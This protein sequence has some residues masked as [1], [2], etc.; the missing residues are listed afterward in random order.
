MS[1]SGPGATSVA[2]A[3]LLSE[4]LSQA[5]DDPGPFSLRPLS[6]GNSNETLELSSDRVSRI[7]RRPP[8]DA[9][10]PSA[11]NMTREFRVLEALH[12]TSVPAPAPLAICNDI[13]LL[14]VPFMVM[15]QVDG[16]AITDTLPDAYRSPGDLPGIGE[17]VIDGLA[18]LQ[19]V[20]WQERGLADFGRPEG[21]LAR[22]LPRWSKQFER[23]RV[24]DLPY[25]K[26]VAS[27]LEDN[28]PPESPPA[29][30]HGDFHLDNCLLSW[31]PPVRLE[32]IIDWEMSTIGDPMLDLGL[33]LAMW[34]DDRPARPAM[35]R[36]Q[37][38][39][40]VPGTPSRDELARRYAE[41]SGRPI[42]H[43]PWYMAL[44]FW[45]LATIIESAYAQFLAGSLT[46][47]YARDLEH[48]V[49]A[50]LAEAAG[51]AD[52]AEPRR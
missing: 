16:V 23:Y 27:W 50:L 49:P 19:S 41:A 31:Q 22:Q 7:L 37:G 5:L 44:A 15:E 36:V 26:E 42:E 25:H 8:A 45:K 33:F 21:F 46:T 2:C 38:V 48:D 6:G 39:T 4:W 20:E 35:P 12:G 28:L 14:G 34:G 43:L 1:V 51:F 10:D 17:S 29:I 9:L 18:A 13:E 32:G 47:P 52:I 30:M 24:R 3:P 40:R 11:H